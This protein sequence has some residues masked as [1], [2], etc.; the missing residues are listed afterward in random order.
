MTTGPSIGSAAAPSDLARGARQR[1]SPVS[2]LFVY[3]GDSG[4]MSGLIHYVHKLVSPATYACNLCALTYGPF[5]RRAA[6]TRSLDELGLESEFLHRDE[7]LRRHG[8]DQPPLPAV[9]AIR[10]GRPEM[11]I[12]RAEIEACRDLD[13]LIALLQD[14]TSALRTEREL[15]LDTSHPAGDVPTEGARR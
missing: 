10:E 9:F 5:G 2:L 1:R 15:R 11:L 12:A 8:P 13:A 6:W 7:L 14:R 4:A 3:A